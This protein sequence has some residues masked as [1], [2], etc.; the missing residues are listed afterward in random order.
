M[1]AKPGGYFKNGKWIAFTW[2]Q[3]I[4]EGLRRRKPKEST[5][6]TCGATLLSPHGNKKYCN[7][8]CKYL[9]ETRDPD[10]VMVKARTVASSVRSTENGTKKQMIYELLSAA[11]DKPCVYCGTIITLKNC[12]LDHKTPVT[13]V[14]GS[15]LSRDLDRRSNLQIICRRCNIAKADLDDAR[16]RRL[17]EFLRTDPVLYGVVWRKLGM[18]G[19]A[20][21]MFKK[22]S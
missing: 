10:P 13:G 2:G 17:L 5:C 21:K 8:R 4:K 22:T 7:Y 9:S 20:W 6:V 16:F 18:S 19:Q 14:R 11:M 3:K 15:P 1:R 12:Q